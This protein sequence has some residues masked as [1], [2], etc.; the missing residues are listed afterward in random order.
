MAAKKKAASKKAAN[1]A[2][3]KR[4]ST[5]SKSKARPAPT[6]AQPKVKTSPTAKKAYLL[7]ALATQQ[8]KAKPAPSPV[9]PPASPELRGAPR[10]GL[11]KRPE[12]MPIGEVTVSDGDRVIELSTFY[13]AEGRDEYIQR[14][15]AR[16]YACR[17][18]PW[19]G[20]A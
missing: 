2:H 9:A 1:K 5:K 11:Q 12:A 3:P 17:F 15:E 7:A 14:W 8:P 4:S 20:L 16:G 6:K 10:P 13:A 18:T 19:N